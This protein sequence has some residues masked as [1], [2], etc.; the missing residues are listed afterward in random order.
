[1]FIV[2]V[3]KVKQPVHCSLF[4]A[5]MLLR[6]AYGLQCHVRNLHV[7]DQMATVGI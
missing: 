5:S 3:C 7:I 6:N 1:M 2:T 4:R